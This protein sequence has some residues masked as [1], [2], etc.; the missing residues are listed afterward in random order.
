MRNPVRKNALCIAIVML[1]TFAAIYCVAC[2]LCRRRRRHRDNFASRRA[3]EVYQ[4]TRVLFNQKGG[5][6][7]YSE[8]KTTLGG[9][10]DPVLYTDV[11]RLWREG[12]LS[13]EEVEK[14]I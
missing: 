2:R 14:V 12:R 5:D 11:R 4:T 3:H 1:L 9:G 6:A 13:P 7:T 10:A 8:Y